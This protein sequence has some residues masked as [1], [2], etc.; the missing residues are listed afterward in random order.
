MLLTYCFYILNDH[1]FLYIL[2]VLGILLVVMSVLDVVKSLSE[3]VE[4]D[5]SPLALLISPLI[6]AATLVRKTLFKLI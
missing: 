2:Q 1:V 6:L 4:K 5:Y 3:R